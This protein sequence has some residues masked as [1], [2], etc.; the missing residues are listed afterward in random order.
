MD[1]IIDLLTNSLIPYIFDQMASQPRLSCNGSKT[2]NCPGLAVCGGNAVRTA[3]SA[4]L[5]VSSLKSENWLCLL[6]FKSVPP[7]W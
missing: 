1:I 2:G 3:A 6:F 5:I 7:F 4:A